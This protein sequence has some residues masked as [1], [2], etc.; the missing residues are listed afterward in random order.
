MKAS[1]FRSIAAV[2]SVLAACCGSPVS[3][4][5]QLSPAALAEVPRIGTHDVTLQLPGGREVLVTLER[6]EILDPQATLV[7]GDLE[8]GDRPL[9]YDRSRLQFFRGG[10]AGGLGGDAFLTQSPRGIEGWVNV[11]DERFV[12]TLPASSEAGAAADVRPMSPVS[13]AGAPLLCPVSDDPRW[14]VTRTPEPESLPVRRHRRTVDLAVETDYEF[15]EVFDNA[16]DAMDYVL[17][18][19]AANSAIFDRDVAVSLNVTFVRLWDDPDDLF[20][21]NDPLG[22]FRAYWNA[23]MQQ[24]QRDV[25]QFFSG[26]RTFPY[27]G[28]AYV[29]SLCGGNGYSVVGYAQGSFEDP[30]YPSVFNRDLIVTAHELGHNFG[31]LHN[32]DYNLD[33]CDDA[34]GAATRGTLLSYCGQTRMGGEANLDPRFDTVTGGRIIAYMRDSRRTCVILDCNGNG[35]ADATDIS[36]G[37]S[38]DAN[39]NGVPDE[40]EDCNANSVLDSIDIAMGDSFDI[41]GNGVPDECQ[42]DCDGDEVP[43]SMQIAADE[44]LD[45]DFD[46]VLDACQVDCDGDLVADTVQ[47]R[48]DMSLDVD[49]DALLDACQDCDQDGT[50][51]LVEL[52]RS[53]FIL[54]ATLDEDRRLQ[55]YHGRTGVLTASHAGPHYDVGYDLVITPDRRVL[56]SSAADDRIVEFTVAGDYVRDLVPAGASGLDLPSAILLSDHGTFLVAS[57]E[58]DA[59]LEF[60]LTTGAYIRDVVSSSSGFL[61]SPFGLLFTPAGTLLATSHDDRVL[62]IDPATGSLIRT[63]VAPGSGGLVFARGMV[64]KRDGNLLVANYGHGQILEFNALTGDFVRVWNRNGSGNVLTLEQP[65]CLRIGH[66]NHIYVSDAHAHESGNPDLLHL[67]AARVMVFDWRNGNYRRSL[68]Q[69]LDSELTHPGGFDFI[70]ATTDCNATFFPDDCEIALGLSFD[71]DLNGIP[72]ECETCPADLSGSTDPN[73]PDY[74]LADGLLDASDFFF[75]LDLFVAGAAAADLSGST[76]INNPQYGKPDGTVDATDFFYFLDLF[77]AGC[78]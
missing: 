54:T 56:V 76:Q 75:Y 2:A 61:E 71:D 10:V 41:D 31:S 27:G 64:L 53:R 49:R 68:I 77:V 6:F 43:D 14:V 13:F 78:P 36:G 72:D 48:L 3:A 45:L 23:N 1:K 7:I 57:R 44:D 15:Y 33:T 73:D 24:V 32:H 8:R 19:Y 66:D 4:Q 30:A 39:A 59:I 12:L 20:T 28:V 65:W 29:G 55:E 21:M 42:A 18:L 40:C 51:D 11:G 5:P 38:Q 50:I 62:E 69:G 37:A 17:S 63:L 26:Q 58:N 74:G 46:G 22:T 52:D 35:I 67:T 9:A 47:I 60:D 16:D 34:M 25:A 70:P